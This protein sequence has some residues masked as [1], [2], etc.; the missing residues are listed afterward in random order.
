M[1]PH[2]GKKSGNSKVD[3]L[4]DFAEKV[5]RTTTAIIKAQ[6]AGAF[7]DDKAFT[8]DVRRSTIESGNA[9]YNFVKILI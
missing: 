7:G 5:T 3:S 1:K 2:R 9:K 6:N 8:Y 4:S